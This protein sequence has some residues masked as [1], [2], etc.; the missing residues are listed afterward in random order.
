MPRFAARVHAAV[1]AERAP[2][3]ELKM[4]LRQH[5]SSRDSRK[6]MS[7]FSLAFKNLISLHGLL[8]FRVRECRN[9]NGPKKAIYPHLTRVGMR[10]ASLF[11][12]RGS[13]RRLLPDLFDLMCFITCT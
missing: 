4:L 13:F 12:T 3:H 9:T 5:P 10:S 8:Q 11:L 1:V 6:A 2:M 7:G